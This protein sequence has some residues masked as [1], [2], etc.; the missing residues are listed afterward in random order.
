MLGNPSKHDYVGM[1][2]ANLVANCPITINNR[3]QP[4]AG[5]RGKTVQN[6]PAQVN[7]DHA[8]IPQKLIESNTKYVTLI[9]DLIFV[10]GLASLITA[11]KEIDGSQ[12]HI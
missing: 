8:Q 4:D 3:K 11:I 10:N 2:Y 12:W 5:L 7:V 1:V 9:T 6:T